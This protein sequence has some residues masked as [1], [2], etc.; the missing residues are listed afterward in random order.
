M[1]MLFPYKNQRPGGS[2]L[3][4]RFSV[5]KCVSL[6]SAS[7]N[8]QIYQFPPH[9]STTK[10]CV[11]QRHPRLNK[12]LFALCT[13]PF[14]FSLFTSPLSLLPFPFSLLTSPFSLLTFHFSLFTSNSHFSLFPSYGMSFP[15]RR[16][17]K[18]RVAACPTIIGEFILSVVEGIFDILSTSF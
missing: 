2:K 9:L 7:C 6:I 4:C 10:I 16:E 13:F 11:N 8:P 1:I 3:N 17:S 15:R 5:I 14:L 12:A 18:G